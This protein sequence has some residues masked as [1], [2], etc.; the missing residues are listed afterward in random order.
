MKKCV[1]SKFPQSRRVLT[2]ELRSILYQKCHYG[3][4]IWRMAGILEFVHLLDGDISA[5]L[6]VQ[7]YN[8]HPRVLQKQQQQNSVHGASKFQ[9]TSWPFCSD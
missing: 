5:P 7:G 3:R 8:T 2:Y 4:R 6:V 1:I 9:Y